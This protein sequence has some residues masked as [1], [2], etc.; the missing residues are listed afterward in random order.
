M[1]AETDSLRALSR[2]AFGQTYRLEV[3]LAIADSDDGLVTL[4]D[5]ARELD[6]ATSNVQ[7]ALRS[8]VGTGLLSE[9]PKDDNRRKYLI[10]NPS[11]AW[12]WVREMRN[13]VRGALVEA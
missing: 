5:L 10:R 6:I 4:T 3:M 1:A 13:H 8:L 2:A 12:E 11:S 9:L 7:V